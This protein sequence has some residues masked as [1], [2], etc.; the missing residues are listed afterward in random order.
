MDGEICQTHQWMILLI[1]KV[2]LGKEGVFFFGEGLDGIVQW[3][4][5]SVWSLDGRL[6]NFNGSDF[7]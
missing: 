5:G 1:L 2:F 3:N 4:S 7:R 6:F